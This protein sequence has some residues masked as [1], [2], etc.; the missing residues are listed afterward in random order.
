MAKNNTQI[1]PSLRV[2][3][4]SLAPEMVVSRKRK[5]RPTVVRRSSGNSFEMVFLLILIGLIKAAT[6]I[7][8]RI[9]IMLLPMTLP[10]SISVLPLIM[11]VM[12]TA[13]SGAP[14]PKAT[15]V[16]PM[17][18]FETLK[19]EATL[20]APSTSQSAPLIKITKPP[21]K[22]KICNSIFVSMLVLYGYVYIISYFFE[23]QQKWCE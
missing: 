18:C 22:S 1:S 15:T 4:F 9:L 21:T 5:T 10:R 14:V 2:I 17:S 16:R 7:K 19:L 23:R 12:E 3:Q 11:E 13:S 6:P 8:R 20:L